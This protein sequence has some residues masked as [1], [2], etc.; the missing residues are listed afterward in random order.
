MVKWCLKFY[1]GVIFTQLAGKV[2]IFARH[3][4]YTS[5]WLQLFTVGLIMQTGA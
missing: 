2:V 3:N 5:T 1:T 4:S